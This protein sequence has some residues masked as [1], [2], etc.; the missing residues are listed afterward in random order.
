[1]KVIA[2]TLLALF[3]IYLALVAYMYFNQ[4][5]LLFHPTIKLAAP[6][7][8]GAV[9]YKEVSITTADNTKLTG[10][11]HKGKSNGK[12][13]V[14]FYGNAD[15]LENYPMLLNKFAGH[16]YSVLAINYRGYGGSE[17][18]PSENGLYEDGRAAINYLK[19]FTPEKNI[20]AVGRSLGTGVATEMAKEFPLG[21]LV[22]ISP[23]TSIPDIGARIYPFL[24]VH[25]VA[26]YQFNTLEKIST[27]TEP[28]LIIHG[29][30]DR[31]IPLS[32][33]QKIYD[34]AKTPKKLD[35][36]AGADHITIPQPKIAQDIFEFVEANHA[37]K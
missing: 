3:V 21:Y 5:A 7:V 33:A 11:F 27:I 29:D 6:D 19:Q 34:A 22:L 17:G 23:Y 14:Y 30:L 16:G 10:W 36:E 1:M 18:Q 2:K 35:V 12:A 8:Y 15:S 37:D 31:M 26:R 24:P 32:N 20:I 4:D 25:L 9:G 28:L 13:L